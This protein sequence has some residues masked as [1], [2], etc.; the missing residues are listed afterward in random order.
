MKWG[1]NFEGQFW[2]LFFK[3]GLSFPILQLL[4]KELSLI[5][6]WQSCEVGLAKISVSSFRN[7]RDKSAMPAALAGLKPFNI[8]NIFLGDVSENS[9]FTSLCLM[10]S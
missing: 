2:S 4:G 3:N 5:E 6:R 10:S 7:F 8:F 9:K 1:G